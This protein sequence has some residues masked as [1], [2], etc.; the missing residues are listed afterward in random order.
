MTSPNFYTCPGTSNAECMVDVVNTS[1]S[2]LLKSNSGTVS[3]NADDEKIY[4]GTAIEIC[5]DGTGGPGTT[6]KAR[7]KASGLLGS[8]T[9]YTNATTGVSLSGPAEAVEI[10]MNCGGLNTDLP[11][12][13]TVTPDSTVD[14]VFWADPTGGIFLTNNGALANATCYDKTPGVVSFCAALPAVF[15]TTI[16]GNIS[17]ERYQLNVTSIPEVG[18]DFYGDV[19]LTVVTNANG[20]P[21][22]AA[23]KQL[24]TNVAN[25]TKTMPMPVIAFD[26][27]TL[28]DSL[29]SFGYMSNSATLTSVLTGLAKTGNSTN[30]KLNILTGSEVTVDA[31]KL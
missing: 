15:G 25:E 5:A 29:Y 10:T 20:T 18:G 1:L 16:G 2:D 3:F 4:T 11:T 12:P 23:T 9:Y 21:I 28:S 8:D 31:K 24:Y 13:I 19:L 27:V 30:L 22:G 26:S 14:L 17:T 6:F 7:V